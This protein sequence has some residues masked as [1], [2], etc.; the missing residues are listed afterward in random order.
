MTKWLFSIFLPFIGCTVFFM[1][2]LRLMRC[3]YGEECL[4]PI[5]FEEVVIS[6]VAVIVILGIAGR[7]PS[8]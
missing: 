7:I 6:A 3:A 8:I 4:Y 5:S 1:L 2:H